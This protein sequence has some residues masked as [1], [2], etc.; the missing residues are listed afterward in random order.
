MSEQ[1]SAPAQDTAGPTDASLNKAEAKEAS[2]APRTIDVEA[3][4]TTTSPQ[5]PSHHPSHTRTLHFIQ[6]A[7]THVVPLLLHIHHHDLPSF[8]PTHFTALLTALQ[9]ALTSPPSDSL[10]THVR[11]AGF[12]AAFYFRPAEH[13]S[14]M[15]RRDGRLCK[16][17]VE[18]RMVVVIVEMGDRKV[19]VDYLGVCYRKV[20]I[21]EFFE[22]G[23]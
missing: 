17:Y 18:R 1:A 11:C 19:P 7:P 2:P 16:M 12:Q 6:K 22:V 21:E 8:T 4:S 3:L 15:V 9:P 13:Q 10:A 5:K 14:M 23:G 20:G